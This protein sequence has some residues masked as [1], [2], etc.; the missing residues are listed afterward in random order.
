MKKAPISALQVKLAIEAIN[1]NEISHSL[2]QQA[3]QICDLL[4]AN[5]LTTTGALYDSVFAGSKD[6]TAANLA[7]NRFFHAINHVFEQTKLDIQFTVLGA[8]KDGRNR[9]VSFNGSVEIQVPPASSLSGIQKTESNF[10]FSQALL[11]KP[12]AV[13]LTTVNSIETRVVLQPLTMLF[14]KKFAITNVNIS[15]LGNMVVIKY[16]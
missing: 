12:R 16:I 5:H 4:D 7:L 3:L 13:V 9:F 11:P 2:R 15:T 6:Q 8:K 14:H 1:T 10:Q